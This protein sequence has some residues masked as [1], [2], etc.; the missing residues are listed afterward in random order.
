MSRAVGIGLGAVAFAAYAAL[1]IHNG[2]AV[3]PSVVGSALGVVVLVL[4]ARR[5]AERRSGRR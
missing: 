4:L 1:R 3:L 5:R 2:A